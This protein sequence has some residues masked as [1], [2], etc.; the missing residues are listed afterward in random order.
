M[1]GLFE[2]G[3][4]CV[5]SGYWVPS[6]TGNHSIYGKTS[7]IL[8]VLKVG[9]DQTNTVYS[10]LYTDRDQASSRM[11]SVLLATVLLVLTGPLLGK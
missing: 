3:L 11:R 6:I 1:Q 9:S 5:G 2:G 8:H 10:T 4:Y 7:D